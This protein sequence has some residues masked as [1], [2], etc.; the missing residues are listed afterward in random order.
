MTVLGDVLRRAGGFRFTGLHAFVPMR[1][2][3]D[4]AVALRG[5]ADWFA[6]ADP[7]GAV[8]L[9][10]TVSERGKSAPGRIAQVRRH[11]EE[12]AYGRMTP[13]ETVEAVEAV[14]AVEPSATTPELPG[15]APTL[16]G[17]VL[18]EGM[19]RRM[20]FRCRVR[21]WSPDVAAW[22]TEVFVDALRASGEAE[23]V[24]VTVSRPARR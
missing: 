19:R 1:L 2:S 11:A 23:P 16:T 10:V 22:V 7:D 6:L 24:L 9:L 17:A 5:A 18:A 20:P 8:D 13:V 21:E 4:A 3:P 14:E 12:S 15:L